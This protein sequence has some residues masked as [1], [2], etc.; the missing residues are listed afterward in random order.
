DILTKEFTE[1]EKEIVREYNETLNDGR[2]FVVDE[3]VNT[4]EYFEIVDDFCDK[5]RNK[6]YI[7]L[8][9]DNILLITGENS[10]ENP[11]ETLAEKTNVLRKKYDNIVFIYLSQLNRYYP[12]EVREK[13]NEMLPKTKHIY[14]SS[15]FEFLSA[16]VVVMAN[17][18][19]MG[20]EEYM[21]VKADRYEDYTDVM[22]EPNSNNLCSFK[23]MG[24]IFYHT[25]KTRE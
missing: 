15:Q 8:S 19:K 6:D 7:I 24:Y 13:S 17:P 1:E 16:Y 25:L 21:R 9:L 14:G 3:S 23:T 18:F 2:R 5:N 4:K 10:A 11:L 22:T 20:V 12:P